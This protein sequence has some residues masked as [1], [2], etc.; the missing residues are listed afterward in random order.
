MRGKMASRGKDLEQRINHL[1]EEL[2]SL[3]ETV[4]KLEGKIT[5]LEKSQHKYSLLD[6]LHA[7]KD[8]SR[9]P[10]DLENRTPEEPLPSWANSASL[11]PRVAAICFILVFALILRTLT[12]NNIINKEAGSFIGMAYSVFLF[13]AGWK[14]L[15]KEKSMGT[16]F[17]TCGALLLFSIILETH[18][19]FESISTFTAYLILFVSILAISGAGFQFRRSGLLCLGMLGTSAVAISIDFPNPH[20]PTLILL[21]WVATIIAHI[22]SNKAIRCNWSRWVL[23]FTTVVVVLSWASKIRVPLRNSDEIGAFLSYPWFFPMLIFLVAT[24]MGLSINK[25]LNKSQ[26]NKFDMALPTLN[27]IWS[28]PA[29]WLVVSLLPDKIFGLG[30]AGVMLSL[31]HFIFAILFFM[32]SKTGRSEGAGV[33]VFTF[34]GATLLVLALPSV[35]GNILSSVAL[36]SVL[37]LGLARLSAVCEIGGIRLTSYLLQVAACSI[38]ILSGGLSIHSTTPVASLFVA[39]LIMSMSGFQYY[40]CRENQ[41]SCS[42][43]FFHSTDPAD[44]SAV[45]LLIVSMINAFILLNI[46]AYLLFRPLAESIDNVMLGLQSVFINIGAIILMLIA[47][48]QRNKELIG[49][50]ILL[51]GIGALKVFGY[52]LFESHGVPLVTSVFS[53]GALAAVGSLTVN[54]W[55][56]RQHIKQHA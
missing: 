6:E 24:Y 31:L 29:A 30:V 51:A 40:W 27:V 37:G 7:S 36:W 46:S 23:F 50:A 14:M 1:T 9:T 54:R 52:D 11:L 2:S 35:T 32:G 13:I 18:A 5:F 22:S 15:A 43:G 42:T 16:V 41:L 25:T 21:L 10:S 49:M 20:F 33:C 45:I 55:Q 47:L 56:H 26:M 48:P 8:N 3:R 4:D 44:R 12:D 34:A 17:Q 28:F 39:G 19:R 53:F 38:G